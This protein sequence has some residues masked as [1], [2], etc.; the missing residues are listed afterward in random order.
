[1]KLWREREHGSILM[2]YAN[3]V[4][5]LYISSRDAVDNPSAP[6]RRQN[7]AGEITGRPRFP[8]QLS[9]SRLTRKEMFLASTLTRKR[10][11]RKKKE[12]EDF[13]SRLRINAIAAQ[14]PMIVTHKVFVVPAV[15]PIARDPAEYSSTFTFD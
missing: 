3:G 10:R 13:R 6:P 7:Q 1:M 14:L 2:V 4:T 12:R 5:C 15:I 8:T 11:Q 9:P